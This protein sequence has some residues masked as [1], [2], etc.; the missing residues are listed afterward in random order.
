MKMFQGELTKLDG[1]QIMLEQQKMTIQSTHS[2]VDVV[3]T[4][5]VGNQAIGNMNKQ[6]DVDSIADLQDEMAENMQE[7]QERQ[8]LFSG[9]AEEGQEDLMAEL[10]DIEAD[11]LAGELEGMEVGNMPIA[12]AA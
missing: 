7:Y 10:D 4:L 3:N 12:A 1:Q 5:K 2:D 8:D 6:M 11:A 9:V